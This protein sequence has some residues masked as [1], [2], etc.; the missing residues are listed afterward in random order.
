ML[1][2]VDKTSEDLQK[3]GL[4]KEDMAI[5]LLTSPERAMTMAPHSVDGYV[6]PYFTL[7]GRSEPF[8]RVRL[9]DHTVKYKQPKDSPS[10]VYFPPEFL[11]V[12]KKSPYILITE[13]EKKAALACKLGF[14][15]CAL[16]GVDAWRNRTITL[17][18]DSELTQ[19]KSKVT[20]KVPSNT[21]GVEDTSGLAV[22]LQDLID[23]VLRNKKHV[24][25]C[26]DSD[27][28]V[29][30]KASVQ[31]AAATFAFDLRFRGIPFNHIRQIILPPV[32]IEAGPLSKDKDPKLGLD[33]WLMQ[34]NKQRFQFLIDKCLAKRSAFPR[35]PAIRDLINK[36][37]Q[38][39][40]LSRKEVQ[41]L[42]IA[43]LSDLD[44]NGIRLRSTQ[45]QQ[46][47]YFDFVTRKLLKTTF[48][49]RN[50]DASSSPFGQFLYRRYGIS[51]ADKF[52][53]TWL[54]AQFTGEDP[55]EE[56]SPH[57]VIARVSPMDD[58][59]R[60]QLSDSQYVK[61]DKSGIEIYDNG[62]HG[63]LFE[64]EQVLPLDPSKIMR[65]FEEFN[66]PTGVINQWSNVLSRVR[67]RDQNS[68]R[69]VTSLLYCMSPWLYRWRGMQLPVEMVLGESGSGKSTLCELRLAI[70]TGDTRLRNSP[71]DLKDWHASISNSGGLHV[72]DNVQ[73]VDR[74]LRQRL[75][76]EICRIITEPNPHIEQRKYYTNNELVRI[77]IR[78]VF[79]LTAI[80]Q[81]FQNADLLQRSIVLELDKSTSEEDGRAAVMYD[82][83]WR[84]SQLDLLGGREGWIA[85]QLVVLHR[86][87]K[88][89]EKKWNSKYQAK[90]RLINFEQ[91]MVLM[92]EVFGEDGS[93]IPSYLASVIDSNL[94][95]SDWTFEG[96]K[97]FTEFASQHFNEDKLWKAGDIVNFA[98]GQEEFEKCEM[99][100]NARRLGRYLQT[101]KS[102][103]ASSLGLVDRGTRS[104]SQVYQV[105]RPKGAKPRPIK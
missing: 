2:Q 83:E 33:D 96:I 30:I 79:A 85:Y 74:S 37:L 91:T 16:A 36:K 72:T 92:A 18:A 15:C 34:A 75:S 23:F 7:Y 3:S 60:Y 86:F 99:L 49:D 4:V 69:K 88:L 25:L 11:A 47:Y 80:S 82:S 27:L 50:N 21:E 73:L 104:N 28:D 43:I 48:I 84:Q 70:L 59:V 102:L 78:A 90:H 97:A 98:M 39:P 17:P 68:Q 55:V 57:R 8:Y 87:F 93:W 35:H 52:L 31:R 41:Q 54:A 81:P 5:R 14:P 10:H 24:I 76:D 22:G 66:T 51:G 32:N 53:I 26:Y 67:L 100:V 63:I 101:H 13:G 103:V 12:A 29:G 95:S 61:V 58:N 40:N 94:A 64:S 105:I 44:A 46:T 19:H 9:F 77:P 42:S 38:R 45:E 71:T 20:A 6:I 89:V 56:V 62:E 65:Y 1:T